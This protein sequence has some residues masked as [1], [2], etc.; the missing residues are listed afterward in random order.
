[1]GTFAGTAIVDYRLLFASWGKQPSV[2]SFL[3]NSVSI[4]FHLRQS[5]GVLRF[6]FASVCSIQKINN[7]VFHV[8]FA[9]V[10]CTKTAL[11]VFRFR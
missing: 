8:P 1:V 10:G 6:A 5:T 3:P 2:F 4:C 11:S 7:S 9:S